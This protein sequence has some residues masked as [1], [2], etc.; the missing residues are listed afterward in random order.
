[1]NNKFTILFL[2]FKCIRFWGKKKK[3]SDAV[4]EFESI[5]SSSLQIKE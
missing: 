3:K 5:K 4:T 2:V 1:M